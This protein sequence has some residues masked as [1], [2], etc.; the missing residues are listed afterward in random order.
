MQRRAFMKLLGGITV[1]SATGFSRALMAQ[2]ASA[3][4]IGFIT[5]GFAEGSEPEV[6]AF[7]RGL[8]ETGFV[9]GR[10]LRIEYRWLHNDRTRIPGLVAQLV[11]LAVAVIATPGSVPAAIEAKAETSTIPIVFSTAGDP[12]RT[13]IVT[14][15]S[16]P[17]GNVTGVASMNHELL[18]KR[19][20]LLLQAV[21]TAAHIAIL[22]NPN[23][24]YA[25]HTAEEARQV[26]ALLGKQVEVLH[27][28]KDSE[29]DTAFASLLEKRADALVVTPATLFYNRRQQLAD[30]ALRHAIPTIH[31]ER[32]NALA[33]GLMSY[34]PDELDQ[35]RQVGV[36]TGR[37]L[38]GE[39]P[40][41]L[42]IAQPTKFDF[43][44]NLKT[45]KALGLTLPTD[46]LAVADA[47][48]E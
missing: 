21:P 1:G 39:K 28:S 42:P 2:P 26:T 5:A 31:F 38:K 37:I 7:R 43:V 22:I 19:I 12:T 48:I 13:G 14:S 8:G 4:V 16:R 10:N 36:Y 40:A 27:A 41:E 18:A 23:S 30:L 46:M 11:G 47:V 45:A 15:L 32:E 6:M 44:V 17:G 35:Y 9:E 33:G 25:E 3:P 20:D 34:G 24:Q 29:I